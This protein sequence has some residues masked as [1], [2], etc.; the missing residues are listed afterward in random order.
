MAFSELK[1]LLTEA[2]ILVYPQF[3]P[4]EHFLLETDASGIGLG[5]VLSQ[6]QKDGEYHPIAYASR[7]L[8]PSEKNYGISELETLA[9]VWAVKYFRTYILGHPCTVLMDHAACLSLLNTPKPLAK[10][11]RWAMAIQEMNLE[12]KYQSGRSNASADAL[13][14]NPVCKDEV[15]EVCAIEAS[16][17][18]GVDVEEDATPTSSFELSDDTKQTLS[19]ISDLQKSDSNLKDMSMYLSE[20]MLPEEDK[21]ARRVILESRHFDLLDG[22]LHHENPHTSGR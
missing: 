9:L 8:Q 10:L 22:V 6:K 18:P 21:A 20:G 7:S 4:R 3:G 16:S 12:I 13:S 11:A 2:P 15:V 14:R 17:T 1:K 19:N 5:A